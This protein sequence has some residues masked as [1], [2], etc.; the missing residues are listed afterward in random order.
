LWFRGELLNSIVNNLF[1]DLTSC[2]NFLIT[3]EDK[4]RGGY[5]SP[6]LL[7]SRLIKQDLE[8]LFHCTF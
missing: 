7:I 8:G 6:P 4:K 5:N 3:I 2:D 1:I